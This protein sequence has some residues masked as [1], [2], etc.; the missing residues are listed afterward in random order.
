MSLLVDFKHRLKKRF[1]LV[2]MV[3]QRLV[4]GMSFTF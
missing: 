3:I 2:P 4:V 1:L